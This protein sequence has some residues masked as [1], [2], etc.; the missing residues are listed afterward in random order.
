MILFP[1]AF[2]WLV[3]VF[4]WLI[5]NSLNEP[6]QPEQQE[7]GPPRRFR[8]RGRGGGRSAL[9]ALDGERRP[10][11]V[12]DAVE[13]APVALVDSPLEPLGVR[14]GF[15][16]LATFGSARLC[17]R[18]TIRLPR[19]RDTVPWDH[20]AAPG[21]IDEECGDCEPE[22]EDQDVQPAV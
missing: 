11:P 21:A 7:P 14:V 19:S 9:L 5:R 8:P 6:E 4:V 12:D 22:Y 2:V 13:L 18:L 10:A 17:R 20:G 16:F 15:W 3:I 1:I